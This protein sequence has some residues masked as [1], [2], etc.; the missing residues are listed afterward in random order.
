MLAGDAV[1]VPA[2]AQAS[3]N[4]YGEWTWMTSSDAPQCLQK[5]GSPADRIA[6]TY[7]NYDWF[8]LNRTAEVDS[9][10]PQAG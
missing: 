2:Y 8:S 7:Y 10:Q 5:P 1:S 4:H 6:A 3:F 9:H